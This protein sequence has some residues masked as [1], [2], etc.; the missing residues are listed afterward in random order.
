MVERK[1]VVALGEDHP[2]VL[3]T[4]HSIAGVL[5]DLGEYDEALTLYQVLERKRVF[6]LGE[7]HPQRARHEE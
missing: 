1:S 5:K 7:D 4:R 6:A 2:S 3:H